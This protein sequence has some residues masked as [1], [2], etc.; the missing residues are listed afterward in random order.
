MNETTSVLFGLIALVISAILFW[1]LDEPEIIE[2]K[3]F[4]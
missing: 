1:V 2:D 3:E 4:S